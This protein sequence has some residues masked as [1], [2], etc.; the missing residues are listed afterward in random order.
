[1]TALAGRPPVRLEP[2]QGHAEPDQFPWR[3]ERLAGARHYADG[4]QRLAYRYGGTRL[5]AFTGPDG[6]AAAY[7]T[8]SDPRWDA[9][10][11]HVRGRVLAAIRRDAARLAREGRGRS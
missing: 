3:L 11:A 6:R 7:V 4:S 1:M 9:T 10:Y 2:P 5:E 8:S